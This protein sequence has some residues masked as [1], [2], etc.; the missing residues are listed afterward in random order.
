LASRLTPSLEQADRGP[1]VNALS[2]SEGF[3]ADLPQLED[4]T[5]ALLEWQA[6]ESLA[7]PTTKIV[8]D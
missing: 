6:G 8:R 5:D 1:A 3:Q 2:L 7:I 4:S